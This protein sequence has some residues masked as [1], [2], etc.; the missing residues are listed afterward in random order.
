MKRIYLLAMVAAVALM[1]ACSQ[2]VPQLNEKNVKKVLKAMTTEEK[3]RLVIGTGMRGFS[4]EGGE[5]VIGETRSIVPGAAGTTAPIPR[6]G[7]PATVLADGPAGLRISPTREGTEDTFY[8][9]GFPVGTVMAC[10]WNTEL[11]EQV[12]KAMGNEVLEYG[13]DVLLAPGVNIMRNPLCGRNFEYYS[14]D[15]LLT[16]KIAAAMINGVQS[17]GVGTSIKHFAVN[18]QE[19]NRSRNDA[20]VSSRALREIYLRG[21]EIAIKES[22]PWTIMTSYNL[23][24]GT[25]TSE[26]RELLKG[27]VRQEWGYEGMF[28]TD[29]G[30]GIDAVAQMHAGNDLLM[31]GNQR[32]ADAIAAAIED[33]S[34]AMEDLDACVENVLNMIVRS[35]RF[36]GYQ[37]S[38]KPDL[39]A[40][41]EVTRNS[42][43]EGMV[44]LKND[45]ATLPFDQS[46]KNIAVFGVTSYD[47]I[48]GGTGSGNVNK[49]YVVDLKEGL[50]NANYT[51]EEEVS[52]FYTEY[53]AAEKARLAAERRGMWGAPTIS[54]LAPDAKLIEK[55]ANNADVA[56]I[57]I[58]RQ[59]G[60][61]SDRKNAQG[62]WLLTDVEQN[63]IADV[64]AKFHAAGKKV[65]VIMNIGGAIETASWK[66]TPDAILL[67][68]Q[69]GQEGGNTVADVLA[70]K[71]NP[72]GKLAMTFAN[73]YD[74]IKSSENFP[75]NYVRPA[76]NAD[77][78]PVQTGPVE[79]VDYTNYEEDI[80]VGYRYFDTFGVDVSYPFGYGLSYTT[81]GYDEAA[82]KA[83]KSG[84]EVSV[85]VTNTGSVAGK[86]VV[87]VYATAPANAA[88]Q[89]AQELVAFGKTKELAPGES[90]VLTMSFTTKDMAWFDEARNAWILDAGD[91]AIT[92]AASSR[93]A[94]AALSVNVA[95]EKVIETVIGDV[96]P[97]HE[98]ALLKK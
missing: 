28:M 35:P 4:G 75:S 21:F 95:K 78:T 50:T 69:C 38:N 84:Y 85:K 7:I 51:M 62:D 1:S 31:P 10:S 34:L 22:D 70:G 36:Q 67:A 42:A 53:I 77:G 26:D 97:E 17:N 66:N 9:T 60:E 32:Q 23:M 57:T 80:Y 52:N 30:G 19:T 27:I 68:W 29:W 33:G 37:Y 49:A 3:I 15:P 41:A 72:S 76:R 91:H 13:A 11:V 79:N 86:E 6:L 47:F 92:V 45:N 61:G 98:L 89:P 81:F 8:C 54:E 59:A 12:G 96:A 2:G 48:A 63:M 94:K 24:N 56:L 74:D 82:V 5:T 20:R 43:A 18:N 90:Q 55:A 39:A 44:L 71:V 65:V 83:V 58:G 25:M 88:G 87:Q 14:E 16:G 46:V 73:N 40:H 64:T 93:D